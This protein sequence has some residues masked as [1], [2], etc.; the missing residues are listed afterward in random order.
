MSD[1]WTAGL[2]KDRG[3]EHFTSTERGG[4]ERASRE[5]GG[6]RWLPWL[7][8]NRAGGAGDASH[9]QSPFPLCVSPC[10]LS[11]SLS[12]SPFSSLE[13]KCTWGGSREQVINLESW[14]WSRE[15]RGKTSFSPSPLP[16]AAKNL[17]FSARG[18]AE[19]FRGKIWDGRSGSIT[20]QVLEPN[21][22]RGSWAGGLR[23]GGE[24]G[25][26]YWLAT[27]H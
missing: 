15:E 27:K 18:K 21:A 23:Y 12:F 19:E 16:L 4:G 10:P 17:T 22:S 9:G 25:R 6:G 3:I 8:G 7:P 5:W 1:L 13:W 24:G 26:A 14:D 2:G 11:L 20:V